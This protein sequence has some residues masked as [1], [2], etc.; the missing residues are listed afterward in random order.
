M[1]AGDH[2]LVPH[3][4][5]SDVVAARLCPTPTEIDEPGAPCWTAFDSR[6]EE[7]LEQPGR[8]AEPWQPALPVTATVISRSPATGRSS[9]SGALDE[10]GEIDEA[11]AR[12]RTRR[13]PRG[14]RT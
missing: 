12:A 2:A 11:G 13:R 3:A 1:L 4:H 7:N 6:F 10:L 14:A 8:V 9:S 5:D